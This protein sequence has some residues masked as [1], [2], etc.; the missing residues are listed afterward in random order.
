MSETSTNTSLHLAE[1]IEDEMRERK[2]T[3]TDLVNHMGPFAD[4]HA[5]GVT[6]LAWEFFLNVRQPDIILGDK[7]ARELATAFNVDAAFFT[8]LHENWRKSQMQPII[9]E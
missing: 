4:K 8:N 6:H 3:L 9:A 1:I 7:M 5:Y 2:W